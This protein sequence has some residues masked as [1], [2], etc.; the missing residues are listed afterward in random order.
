[1]AWNGFTSLIVL[2]P[3]KLFDSDFYIKNVLPLVEKHG[4]RLIGPKFIFQKDG[5]TF[6]TSEVTI[7]ELNKL[8]I[9]YMRP[10][11]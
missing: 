7:N 9:S 4:T 5:A 11:R 2:P 6:Y 1:M 3:K 10:K 8:D